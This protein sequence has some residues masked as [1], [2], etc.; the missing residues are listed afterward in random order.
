MKTLRDAFKSEDS[1]KISSKRWRFNYQTPKKDNDFISK[2]HKR[3][4]ILLQNSSKKIIISKPS[5]EGRLQYKTP[6]TKKI[7]I[8]K[9]FKRMKTSF[10]NPLQ[11]LKWESW[12]SLFQC[13]IKF[14]FH[15]ALIILQLFSSKI[16]KWF[17]KESFLKGKTFVCVIYIIIFHS[18]QRD[19]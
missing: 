13:S 7:F 6:Q 9:Y 16:S 15:V 10:N 3:M 4:K 14:H 17:L 5:K 8:A 1:L 11:D 18:Q 2:L 12:E 19:F